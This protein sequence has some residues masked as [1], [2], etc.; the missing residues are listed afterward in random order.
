M[1]CQLHIGQ[2]FKSILVSHR[3]RAASASIEYNLIGK[4]DVELFDGSTINGEI[5]QR[6]ELEIRTQAGSK[7]RI[8]PR[9]PKWIADQSQIDMSDECLQERYQD[10][11]SHSHGI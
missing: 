3:S 10:R 6:C 4:V 2:L 1:Q 5:E 9:I 7:S 8:N 11:Y